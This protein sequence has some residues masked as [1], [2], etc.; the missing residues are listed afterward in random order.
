M[1]AVPL[2]EAC[3]CAVSPFLQVLPVSHGLQ[4]PWLVAVAVLGALDE[5]F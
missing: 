4:Q 5:R 2:Q 3:L 1:E